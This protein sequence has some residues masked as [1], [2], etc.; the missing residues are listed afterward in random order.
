LS[1]FEVLVDHIFDF[2]FPNSVPLIQS[3]AKNRGVDVI[4]S[5]QLSG[6]YVVGAISILSDFGQFINITGKALHKLPLAFKQNKDA[7]KIFIGD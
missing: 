5:Q 3:V 4:F 1:R 7:L 2:T 6:P